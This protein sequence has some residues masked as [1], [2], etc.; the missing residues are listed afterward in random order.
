ML[1]NHKSTTLYYAVFEANPETIGEFQ[2]RLETMRR[3]SREAAVEHDK[4]AFRP[5]WACNPKCVRSPPATDPRKS[6]RINGKRKSSGNSATAFRTVAARSDDWRFSSGT[7][8]GSTNCSL[9]VAPGFLILRIEGNLR[10]PRAITIAVLHEIGCDRVKPRRKILPAVKLRA[11]LIHTH[12]CL[13]CHVSGVVLVLQ[14]ANK[15]VKQALAVPPHQ[16]VQR[17]V[18]ASIQA[19]HVRAIPVRIHRRSHGVGCE[20]ADEG[21]VGAIF[22]GVN[23]SF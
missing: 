15:I 1:L 20:S 21:W 6:A 2:L 7:A 18:I 11:M 10:M 5:P 16:F 22:P 4:C 17:H 9:N 23:T 12:E 14:G 8:V 13:L 3:A 19:G